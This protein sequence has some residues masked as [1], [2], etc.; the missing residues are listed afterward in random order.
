[1]NA[2]DFESKLRQ[3]PFRSLPTEWREDILRA[4][5]TG[6]SSQPSTIN[7]QPQL[8][9]RDWLWPSPVAWAGLAAAWVA[10]IALNLAAGAPAVAGNPP[11]VRGS[12]AS[13]GA[14]WVMQQRMMTELLE[15]PAVEPAE[16]PRRA[17]TPRGSGA[18]ST[19]IVRQR[20]C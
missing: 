11:V 14:Y 1:M 13:F 16:P 5:R 8:R 6:L 15:T 9:W 20:Y 10:I 3:Q 12:L 17:V 4:T 2:D 19:L 7:H 18:S